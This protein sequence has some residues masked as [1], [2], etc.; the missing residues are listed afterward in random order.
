MTDKSY[1]KKANFEFKD[2]VLGTWNP[3]YVDHT[4]GYV[5]DI[6][7]QFTYNSRWGDPYWE[8]YETRR[9]EST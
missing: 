4:T 8:L 1:V 6:S 2:K 7:G 3:I 5:T 9:K